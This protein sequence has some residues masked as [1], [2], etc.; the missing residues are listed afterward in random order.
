M[1]LL[2]DI[3]RQIT[4]G[5]VY[6]FAFGPKGFAIARLD[7]SPL[8]LAYEVLPSRIALPYDAGLVERELRE[9]RWFGGVEPFESE[10]GIPRPG[11]RALTI[12][13]A[14]FGYPYVI[15]KERSR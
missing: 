12:E 2:T 4:P 7:H 11:R 8:L 13:A 10:F 15:H 1:P 14:S 5:E 6:Q 3:V 9:V